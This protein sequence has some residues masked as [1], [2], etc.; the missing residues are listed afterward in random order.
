MKRK[1]PYLLPEDIEPV[2]YN[3]SLAPDLEKFT[4]LGFETVTI[5]I[6]KPTKKIT[7]HAV[8]I[9]IKDASLCYADQSEGVGFTNKQISYSKKFETVTLECD[10]E[11][12]PGEAFLN[13]GFEG[14]LNDQMHGFYRT[15]YIL[16]G[17]KTWG[18]ATQLE[19]TDARRCFPCWDQPNKKATFELNITVPED[20][21][22]IFNTDPKEI[23]H[24]DN[25]YKIVSFPKTPKM[26]TYPV[27]IIIAHL[28]SIEGKD[29]NG[30][31]HR[32]WA[33]P[34]KEEHGKF[35]LECSIASV[36]FYEKKTGISYKSI[37]TDS[38]KLD[39]IAC[40]DFASGAM[41]NL[42]AIT[43]RETA[44]LIDP[45]ND[46]AAARERV[47]EVVEHENAHMWF[48]D[49]VTMQWWNG[50][51]LNEG[52]ATFMSHC[53]MHDEF[54]EWDVWTGFVAGDFRS[55]LH[56][57]SMKNSHPIEIDVQN[58]YE[59]R[60]IFDEIT[61]A[62]G[63]VV[64]RMCE[65]YLGEDF[66]KGL[67][68]YLNRFSYKNADT[69]DLWQ[70]LEEASGKPVRDIMAR[71]T[72][73]PGYPVV[74]VSNPS[75]IVNSDGTVA[76]S[77]EQKR[78]FAD[79]RKDKENLLWNIPINILYSRS[80]QNES[81]HESFLMRKKSSKIKIPAFKGLRTFIKLNA[82]QSGIYRV[83]YADGMW[84]CLVEAVKRGELSKTDRIG[85]LDD[86]LALAKAGYMKTSQ[87]LDMIAAQENDK[88]FDGNVWS[89][90]I[91][92]LGALDHV[93]SGDK[94]AGTNLAEFARQ[95]LWPVARK[96]GWN[97]LPGEKH[98]DTLLRS[99][100]LMSLGKYESLATIEEAQIVFANRKKGRTLDPDL[101]NVV[102]SL[103]A[104]NGGAEEF[105][106]LLKIYRATEDA[107]EKERIQVAIAA[108]K[109]EEMIEK[110]LKFSISDEVRK[111]DWFRI[112]VM[113]GQN[114][115][116]R[117][118]VW[119]FLKDNWGDFKKKYE[120]NLTLI[121]RTLEGIV[122]S[123]VDEE[124]LSDVKKFFKAHPLKEAKRTMKQV[125]ETI[126]TNIKWRNRDI[127]NIKNWLAKR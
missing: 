75:H 39:M 73:Q 3:I 86:S 125:V 43:Y 110:V 9:K 68:I 98:T 119:N 23:R 53:A 6:L 120:G 62:K 65:Q 31:S 99:A 64:N 20:R 100:T 121:V 106:E 15:W 83:A 96:L 45:K 49:L 2:H 48:G 114:P 25:G 56:L 46:T 38:P 61:Y 77:L 1:N 40:P 21:T 117:L 35:A 37:A 102:Y 11:L 30:V 85:L 79:G 60:E 59:I 12:N 116:A 4:F 109:S 81:A 94:V 28:K 127:E 123:F 42:G 97:K 54:P 87:A 107:R 108:F 111:Q 90:V 70:A 27:A 103:V 115:K 84:D 34:G 72:K 66:W 67:R 32:V 36:E 71:Y 89:V 5:D 58:P 18:A 14:S 24:L 93:L 91:S 95:L 63:S 47:A 101:K 118:T 126:E 52:F 69:V 44:A 26:S 8:D 112:M 13:I 88:E 22:A 7:L 50:L 74:S 113:L 51:W 17:K 82:G 55:A 104:A 10:R 105:E 41:E 92:N 29:K 76:L 122:N 16:D 19:S 124:N 57:D 78:F 80:G 33:I